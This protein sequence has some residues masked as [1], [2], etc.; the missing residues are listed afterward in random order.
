MALLDDPKMRRYVEETVGPE[1]LRLVELLATKSEATDSQLAEALG[2]KPSH[3]RKILY[4]LY[5][6]R[7]AEY[8]KTKDKETGWLT[9]FWRI[10]PQHAEY[11]LGQKL[12]REILKLQEKLLFEQE[13][14]F[15]IC[16]SGMERFDFAIA[17]EHNFSC[18][19]HGEVLQAYDNAV[20]I[21]KIRQKLVELKSRV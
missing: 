7:V 15:F 20:E 6:A 16:P 13:H 3:I 4:D 9:F 17:T 8:Q 11:A 12:Q 14:E 21:G 19:E 1:G 2:S 10:N 5:E 18:P